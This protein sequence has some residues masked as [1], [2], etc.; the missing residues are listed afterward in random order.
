MFALTDRRSRTAA[1]GEG[2]FGLAAGRLWR[3][4]RHAQ[5]VAGQHSRTQPL[6]VLS[7]VTPHV[8]ELV[9]VG[10]RGG[11]RGVAWPATARVRTTRITVTHNQCIKHAS[12]LQGSS[13]VFKISLRFFI[14]S[15]L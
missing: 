3:A 9:R 8:L 6:S 4:R 7:P 5:V 1:A 2:L 12:M 14:V 11:T 15:D 10:R 13:L